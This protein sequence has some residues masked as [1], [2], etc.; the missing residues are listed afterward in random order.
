MAHFAQIDKETKLVINVIKI[1]D[2][3]LTNNSSESQEVE[4]LGIDFINTIIPDSENYIWKQTSINANI[5]GCTASIGGTYDE[6]LDIFKPIKWHSSWIWN[7]D[8][9][10]WAPPIPKP[11][12]TEQEL[13]N[14]EYVWDDELYQS[15]NTK[16]WVLKVYNIED[17][18]GSPVQTESLPQ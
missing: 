12:L 1:D 7:N 9:N 5:R 18:E 13:V 2:S 3:V 17:L 4:Q 16:G 8:E 14:C 15:D 6:D 11:E 10:Q